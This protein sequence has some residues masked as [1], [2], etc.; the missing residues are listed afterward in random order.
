MRE[1]AVTEALPQK[2]WANKRMINNKRAPVSPTESKKI[3]TMGFPDSGLRTLSRSWIPKVSARRY[4]SPATKETP[5]AIMIPTG[6]ATSA[7]MVS[8]VMWAE[9]S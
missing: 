8:S 4:P 1:L 3:W 2:N 5:T 7:F 9:A 6:P